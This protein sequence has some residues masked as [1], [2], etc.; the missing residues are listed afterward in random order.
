MARSPFFRVERELQIFYC[1]VDTEIS[2]ELDV[3]RIVQLSSYLELKMIQM[4]SLIVEGILMVK[5]GFHLFSFKKTI[6][7]AVGCN[8]RSGWQ[9]SLNGCIL[10][11]EIPKKFPSTDEFPCLL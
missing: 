1:T 10:Q 9:L 2:L 4:F 3:L 6:Y 11:E 7:I 8:L 5:S